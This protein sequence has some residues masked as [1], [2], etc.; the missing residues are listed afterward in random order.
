MVSLY[1]QEGLWKIPEKWK[2]RRDIC[3]VLETL[4]HHHDIQS[5]LLHG[6]YP[7]YHFI[8][9]SQIAEIPSKMSRTGQMPPTKENVPEKMIFF[10]FHCFT[11]I[12]AD[13]ANMRKWKSIYQNH[14]TTTLCRCR[15]ANKYWV[16]WR[17]LPTLRYY[18]T[19][20]TINQRN[21]RTNHFQH[22][23]RH[24]FKK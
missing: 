24:E 23:S 8:N 13:K 2:H 1:A 4:R 16:N 22:S 14:F 12:Q 6:N 18:W 19:L 15:H 11:N 20:R 17:K 10:L 9:I 7:R 5:F 21:S 3:S